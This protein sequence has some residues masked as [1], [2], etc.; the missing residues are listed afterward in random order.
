M[1][2]DRKVVHI[3]IGAEA[4]S[5]SGLAHGFDAA[6]HI[7]PGSGQSAAAQSN[8]MT[9]EKIEDFAMHAQSVPGICRSIKSQKLHLPLLHANH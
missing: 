2:E 5:G 9:R 4:H 6:P 8:A 1:A 3:W 7:S